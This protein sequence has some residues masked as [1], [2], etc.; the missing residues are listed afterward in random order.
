MEQL[1]NSVSFYRQE[2][3][4]FTHWASFML[5]PWATV[6]NSAKFSQSVFRENNTIK[7][8]VNYKLRLEG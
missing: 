8:S 5:V 4:K 6:I 7:A 2:V 1:G 3:L